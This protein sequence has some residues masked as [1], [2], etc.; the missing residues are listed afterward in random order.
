MTI[1]FSSNASD[2][3]EILSILKIILKLMSLKQSA[4]YVCLCL[5]LSAIV[6]SR[7]WKAHN[8]IIDLDRFCVQLKVIKFMIFKVRQTLRKLFV[9]DH[10]FREHLPGV[11]HGDPLAGLFLLSFGISYNVCT[12][13]K[14]SQ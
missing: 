5:I 10:L 7:A 14:K 2:S 1:E 3:Y 4:R 8:S 9:G 6:I 13:G 11:K 12:R